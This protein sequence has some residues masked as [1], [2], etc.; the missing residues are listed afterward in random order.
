[1]VPI[2][3]IQDPNLKDLNF[4]DPNLKDLNFKDHGNV[5][6]CPS[7]LAKT[8]TILGIAMPQDSLINAQS[9]AIIHDENGDALLPDPELDPGQA[10][11]QDDVLD[12]QVDAELPTNAKTGFNKLLSLLPMTV[13]WGLAAQ[14]VLSISRLLTSVT[15]GG[16]FGSGSEEQ[17]GYYS[18]AFGVLMILVGLHEAFVTTPLTVFNQTKGEDERKSF[19]GNMLITSLLVIGLIAAGTGV[20]IA[21]QSGFEVLK[22]ELGAAL[23]AA[24]ALAP[25][26]LVREFSRRWLL[27]NLD[28]K[29]SAWLE[30]FFAAVYLVVLASLVVF[31]QRQR[32]LGV[33]RDR[34][35]QRGWFGGLVVHLSRP[36]SIHACIYVGASR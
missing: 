6:R 12:E 3:P 16:R 1:M 17:L 21:I 28:V 18:S 34:M 35:R 22:P 33:R 10:A 30:C 26:Q 9:P 24:A 11:N 29:A 25:L 27:A 14:G 7:H 8:P 5:V 31:R 19:S 32:D 23:I 2:N 36:F 4:K 13:F 15:V 20:L